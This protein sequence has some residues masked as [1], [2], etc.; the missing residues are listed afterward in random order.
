MTAL[1]FTLTQQ[2]YEA[3][4]GF[5][6]AGTLD[7]AGQ[8]VHDKALRLEAFLRMIE[9][10][11]GVTRDIVWLQWQETGVPLPAGTSFPKRWPPE[12]RVRVEL[13]TRPISRADLEESLAAHAHNPMNVLY[14][15]D[16]GAVYGW[17]EFSKYV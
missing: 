17:E 4:L 11:N 5:A 15:R 3:L 9:E 8:V 13:V 12:L 2:D 10:K 6:R 14:T 16:P 1:T 7:G